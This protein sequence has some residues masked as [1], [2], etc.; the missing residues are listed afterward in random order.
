MFHLKSHPPLAPLRDAIERIEREGLEVALGGSGL[1]GALGLGD[2][3]RDWDLTTD[4]PPQRIAALFPAGSFDLVGS[5]GV[6]ADHKLGLG[7]GVVEVICRFAFNV[8]G[9]VAHIPTIVR[10]R[11]EGIPLGSPEAWA[12]AYA[13]LERAAKSEALFGWLETHGA[14]RDAVE[15]LLAEPLPHAL[16]SR[17]RALPGARPSP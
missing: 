4:E 5:S 15:R 3:A 17:L 13:L 10:E 9:G 12:I 2:M 6:H 7:G 14:D 1:L 11:R 16:A 8:E